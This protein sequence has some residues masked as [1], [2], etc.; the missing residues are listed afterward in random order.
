MKTPAFFRERNRLILNASQDSSNREK[1]QGQRVN[2]DFEVLTYGIT[3]GEFANI[4]DLSKISVPKG[5]E[6]W[7]LSFT[8]QMTYN[9]WFEMHPE[10]VCGDQE[11]TSSIYFPVR[12]K[13]T[14]ED[15]LNAINQ[16]LSGRNSDGTRQD[17]KNSDVIR[18]RKKA[19]LILKI[20]IAA[21]ALKIKL[22]S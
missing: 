17:A 19:L 13:G 18:A 15:V 2:N 3:Q 16:T 10:K 14:K 21:A 9:T 12:I 1:Y 5:Q 7:P 8:E 11:V 20:K 6:E 4:N 22:D